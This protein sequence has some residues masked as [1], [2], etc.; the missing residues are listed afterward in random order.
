LFIIFGAQSRCKRL[1]VD[2]DSLVSLFGFV[3]FSGESD[4]SALDNPQPVFAIDL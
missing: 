3:S 2:W 1:D 4:G